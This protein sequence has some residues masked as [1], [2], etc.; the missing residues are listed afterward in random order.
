MAP[1]EVP[2]PD[3]R[4]ILGCRVDALTLASATER[5]LGWAQRGESRY[6]CVAAVNNVM[7]GRSDPDFLRVH[8]EADLVT[9]DGMPL[10]WGLRLLG[11][12]RAERVY[13]LELTVHICEAAA[14]AGVPVGFY[15]G[16]PEVLGEL[17]E[18]IRDRYPGLRIVYVQSPPFRPLDEAEDREVVEAI[19]AS[20][21][22]ILFVGLGCPKQERWMAEHRGRVAAVMLGVGA[23]FDFLAGRKPVAPAWMQRSGLEWLF[24]LATEPRRLWRRY[25]FQ[26]PVFIALFTAQLIRSRRVGTG[27]PG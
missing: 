12:E 27:T 11:L 21:A 19:R 26:N 18:G 20:G 14:R 15:G 23:A 5:V 25:T 4:S 2:P 9:S 3:Q 6:V 8:N 10:V 13:G 16:A 22:R 1:S 17:T 24:R 7:T